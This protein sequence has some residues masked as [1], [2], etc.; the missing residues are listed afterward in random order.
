MGEQTPIVFHRFGPDRAWKPGSPDLR[1]PGAVMTV[2]TDF[3]ELAQSLSERLGPAAMNEIITLLE[4]HKHD[5]H[6]E[7]PS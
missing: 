3:R 5:T 4:R 2:P 1:V 7:R 6:P